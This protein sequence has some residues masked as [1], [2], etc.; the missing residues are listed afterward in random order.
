MTRRSFMGK[1]GRTA[2]L[3]AAGPTIATLLVDD[4]EARV[5][6]QSGI[7][8]KC[9]TFDCDEV[10]GWCW[11]ATGCCADGLLKKICDCCAP[12]YP[13][14]H[15]YCPAGTNVKC[16]VESCGTDPR[17]QTVSISRM[18]TDNV[19]EIELYSRDSRF[20]IGAVQAVIGDSD[21]LFA[22]VAVAFAGVIGAPVFLV[23][24][25]DLDPSVITQIVQ[26]WGPSVKIVGSN[27]PASIDQQLTDHAIPNERVGVA[28]D[29]ETFSGEVAAWV[30]NNVG[31]RSVVCIANSG[32]S[33]AAAPI[34]SA[35]ASS[36]K[37]PLIVGPDTPRAGGGMYLIGP[38]AAA[39]IGDF[40]GA[41]VIDG[42]NLHTISARMIPH[43]RSMGVSTG[44]ML[45]TPLGW[46]AL[47]GLAGFGGPILVHDPGSLVGVRDL[48]LEVRDRVS[49]VILFG[50]QG[51]DA[52]S[53]QS[54]QSIV[55]RFEIH[56]LIGVAGQG[57]PV[58]SQPPPERE[59]GRARLGTD[60]APPR[61]RGRWT[62]RTRRRRRR[63]RR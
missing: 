26:R 28:L 38:E 41:V 20:P 4:A 51:I 45:L 50:T 53:Y 23:P 17:M 60:P 47:W 46:P 12:A 21:G 6:G 29:V 57:L 49:R 33:A 9:A 7:S 39:R 25:A 44:T 8:T 11:Y 61:P 58:Y 36:A 27:L 13:N 2:V 34:A 10:W 5:C 40:P 62:R 18:G 35:F 37:M 30:A 32:S 63:R 48:L 56:K 3:V 22:G 1:F 59:M 15:G 52:D 19:A 14:V 16:I 55:N 43:A 54:L 24:R 42:E 31:A